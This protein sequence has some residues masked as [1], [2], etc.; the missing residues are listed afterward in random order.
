MDAMS[1]TLN[2]LGGQL[3]ETEIRKLY[4]LSTGGVS[5]MQCVI[6][7]PVG[8]ILVIR[9]TELITPYGGTADRFYRRLFLPTT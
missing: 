6:A 2:G 4:R 1:T 9:I 3:R 8:I 5:V 7:F